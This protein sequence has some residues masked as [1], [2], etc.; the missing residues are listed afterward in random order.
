[1]G[2]T[3]DLIGLLCFALI[4]AVIGY[5]IYTGW[6]SLTG[7]LAIRRVE[8]RASQAQ[9]EA[10]RLREAAELAEAQAAREKARGEA[11]ALRIDA[12]AA[13]E[14]IE[15]GARTINRQSF[16][17]LLYGVL[18]PVG[19]VIGLVLAIVAGLAIGALIVMGS[20][21]VK[22]SE[23]TKDMGD[24]VQA[25]LRKKAKRKYHEQ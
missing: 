20:A 21:K 5:A 22:R 1:M 10:D 18:T 19:V 8:A 23:V 2:N 14:V 7:Q 16:I 15:A 17:A 12:G 6:T 25:F 24:F 9:A 11:D 13:A 3:K 4:I